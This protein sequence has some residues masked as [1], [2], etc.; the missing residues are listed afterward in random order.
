V[1][2]Q[3]PR[4]ISLRAKRTAVTGRGRCQMPWRRRMTMHYHFISGRSFIIARCSM[5]SAVRFACPKAACLPCRRCTVVGLHITLQIIVGVHSTWLS[6]IRY[7]MLPSL[8]AANPF[9]T[10]GRRCRRFLIDLLQ[11]NMVSSVSVVSYSSRQIN[12]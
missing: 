6:A 4:N 10:T 2:G 1:I 3:S 11:F 9:Y 7:E 5:T 12:W 8:A